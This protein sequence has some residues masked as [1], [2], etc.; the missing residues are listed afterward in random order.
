M[1]KRVD[2]HVSD[3]LRELEARRDHDDPNEDPPSAHVDV[4]DDGEA[5]IDTALIPW[6]VPRPPDAPPPRKRTGVR[7]PEPDRERRAYVEQLWR[8]GY[9]DT[10]IVDIVGSRFPQYAATTVR[11]DIRRVRKLY[12]EADSAPDVIAARKAQMVATFQDLAREARA[13]GDRS[14]ARYAYDKVCRIYGL[15]APTKIEATTTQRVEVG[16]QIEVIVNH[17]DADGLRALEVVMHQLEAAGIFKPRDQ[18]SQP[19]L[20]AGSVIDVDSVESDEDQDDTEHDDDD[21]D[22]D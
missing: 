9:A 18:P 10:E 12:V 21:D 7:G 4:T 14:T 11:S 15:Y 3:A 20:A 6:R 1:S 19:E 16:L 13:A 17:L 5:F 22:H 2:L 8:S